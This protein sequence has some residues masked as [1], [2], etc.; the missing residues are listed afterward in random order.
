MPTTGDPLHHASDGLGENRHHGT[1]PWSRF[2]G[3]RGVGAIG[4][5]WRT[6]AAEVRAALAAWRASTEALVTA[7]RRG[8]RID[9]ITRLEASC[10]A[11]LA[12]LQRAVDHQRSARNTALDH[13]L[14]REPA[15]RIGTD[16]RAVPSEVDRGRGDGR[17]GI[18]RSGPV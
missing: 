13:L 7:M 18:T 16:P 2:A 12:E 14:H 17:T 11:R 4:R 10:T 6:A 9:D 1:D 8:D 3:V 15:S 5:E